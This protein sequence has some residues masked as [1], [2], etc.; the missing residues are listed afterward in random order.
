M[1]SPLLFVGPCSAESEEQL[2]TTA[3][4]LKKLKGKV[5]FRAGIWKPRTKPGGFEGIGSI[6]LPWLARVQNDFSLPVAIEVANREHV[7]EAL[8]FGIR[9]FWI[10]ARTTV[11]PFY[12][13]EIADAVSGN[14]EVQVWV[15]N[16]LHPDVHLWEGAIERFQK[17]NIGQVG[18]IHRGFFAI[19]EKKLRNAPRWSIPISLRTNQPNLP[20]ICDISHIAGSSDW[21]LPLAQEAI[22]LN[23]DGWM[24]EVHPHPESAWTDAAQQITPNTL[25]KLLSQIKKRA[26]NP[27]NTIETNIKL[28]RQKIDACDALI[29]QA[30]D[31]RMALVKEIACY[32]KINNLPILQNDR[33]QSVVANYFSGLPSEYIS[34]N[35]IL[36]LTELIHEEAIQIQHKYMNL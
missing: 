21:L 6:G 32:K 13:Q 5:I 1:S 25:K 18:A 7:Q 4:A 23:F 10:G 22:D 2:Y 14:S 3:K 12:V 33:W 34:D 36:R 16:P 15:K 31:Q 8:A 11:N 20:L 30:L 28:L 29:M 17:A 27:P 24:I 9:I 19:E 26:A 35:F